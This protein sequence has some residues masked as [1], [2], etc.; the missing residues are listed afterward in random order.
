MQVHYLENF[1]QSIFDSHNNDEYEGKSLVV[2]GD[3][4]YYNDYAIDVKLLKII[5]RQ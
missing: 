3:G 4:R 2:G 1:I 5:F